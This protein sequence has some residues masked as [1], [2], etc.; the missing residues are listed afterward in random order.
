MVHSIH[1]SIA[2]GAMVNVQCFI[3][4]TPLAIPSCLLGYVPCVP[5]LSLRRRTRLYRSHITP[6]HQD[7][8]NY[9]EGIQQKTG[10]RTQHHY[11]RVQL[12]QNEPKSDSYKTLA[13]SS[14]GSRYEQRIIYSSQSIILTIWRYRER[15][16]LFHTS[17]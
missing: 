1:A 8:G 2:H 4:I 15:D 12:E 7:G 3:G 11:P 6:D 9:E 17:T 10:R 16:E 5:N 13:H 14:R